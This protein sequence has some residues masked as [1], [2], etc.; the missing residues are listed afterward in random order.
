M[1]GENESDTAFWV[2]YTVVMLG[3]ILGGAAWVT[4]RLVTAVQAAP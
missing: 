2:V 1:Q 4:W 3:L